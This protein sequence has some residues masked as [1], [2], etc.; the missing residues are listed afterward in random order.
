MLAECRHRTSRLRRAGFKTRSWT[1]V[2]TIV[3][4]LLQGTAHRC[5]LEQKP[6]EGNRRSPLR[7]A[8]RHFRTAKRCYHYGVQKLAIRITRRVLAAANEG[9]E[10]VQRRIL[11]QRLVSALGFGTHV[12]HGSKYTIARFLWTHAQPREMN[13][14]A[15]YVSRELLVAS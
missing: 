12:A 9:Q 10:P 7:L 3:V 11:R 8:V 5:I 13:V 14:T 6:L 15:V 1:L 2:R 4:R